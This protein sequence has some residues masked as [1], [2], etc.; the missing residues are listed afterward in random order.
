MLQTL[1]DQF[2][3]VFGAYSPILTTD[4]NGVT[5]A[6][7]DFAYIGMIAF[8]LILLWGVLSVMRSIISAIYR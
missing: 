7:P 3:S 8:S 5:V 4:G 1:Y 2:V 6:A